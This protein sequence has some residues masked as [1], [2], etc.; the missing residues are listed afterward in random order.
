MSDPDSIIVAPMHSHVGAVGNDSWEAQAAAN[1]G[2]LAH[3]GDAPGS[4]RL[5]IGLALKSS[6]KQVSRR[7][8]TLITRP[9]FDPAR[10]GGLL[11]AS[12]ICIVPA[13]RADALRYV[14]TR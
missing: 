12:H 9:R 2:V 5:G 10:S 3:D 4:G 11:D 14:V 8:A 6:G 1:V 13:H 7:A